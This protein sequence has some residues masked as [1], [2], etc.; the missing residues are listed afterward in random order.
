MVSVIDPEVIALG[1]VWQLR[2]KRYQDRQTARIGWSA[3]EG[4]VLKGTRDGNLLTGDIKVWGS[5]GG[6]VIVHAL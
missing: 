4:S 1:K 6:H 3:V 2:H 5:P